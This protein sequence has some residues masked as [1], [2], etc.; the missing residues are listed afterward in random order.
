MEQFF[1]A[2]Y[3]A[4]LDAMLYP[5]V[6]GLSYYFFFVSVMALRWLGL[7]QMQSVSVPRT[8]NNPAT[9][10]MEGIVDFHHFLYFFLF[11]IITL[12][13]WFLYR[14]V[15]TYYLD[16]SLNSAGEHVRYLRNQPV[17][18]PLLEI[19]W[20]M[21]PALILLVI[22]VPSF[23]LLYSTNDLVNPLIT[24]KAI[25]HQWYWVYEYSDPVSYLIEKKTKE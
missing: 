16:N 22:S 4:M 9:S 21:L 17:E 8:F 12:I 24:V 7:N 23:T 14:I 3:Y 2:L 18:N 5:S 19:I 11:M 15:E 6:G 13:S 20:T 1:D 10:A 25:G